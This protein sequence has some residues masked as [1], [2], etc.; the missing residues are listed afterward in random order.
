VVP[1]IQPSPADFKAAL[2][3]FAESK[4][5]ALEKLT[6]S[7]ALKEKA[8][9]GCPPKL[10]SD[11]RM[12]L[13]GES[14]QAITARSP[15]FARHL[16]WMPVQT[17]RA[18]TETIQRGDA[19]EC[20][21]DGARICGVLYGYDFKGRPVILQKGGK[22]RTGT[23]DK[24]RVLTA[25]L[26]T[27]TQPVVGMNATTVSTPSPVLD[28]GLKAALD[29]AVCGAHTAREYVNALSA[30]GY[31]VF[32]VGGALRDA[33][34]TQRENP[35]AT[36]ADLAKALSDVDLVTTA[37]VS[38]LREIAAQIAPELPGAGIHSPNVVDQFGVVLVGGPKAHLPNK[39][40]L[41]LASLRSAG[42]GERQT[43]N[44]DT[45]D[46]VVPLVFDHNIEE[47][48]WARDFACNSIYAHYDP[49]SGG[50]SLVD[51]TGHG[52]EDAE[53]LFLRVNRAHLAK[54]EDLSL[55]FFKFRM[56]GYASDAENIALAKG[57]AER[58][59]KSLG[60]KRLANAVLRIMPKDVKTPEALDAYLS[61]L[62]ATMAADG[63]ATLFDD[64]VTKVRDRVWAKLQL[65]L[66][67][68]A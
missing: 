6:L 28:A 63:C 46:T 43:Y 38:V 39:E 35:H 25:P 19:I 1:N 17:G 16:D 14:K 40:G 64:H 20:M 61:K 12:Q 49:K 48:A 67:T 13:I 65:R 54:S 29:L 15:L 53:N 60:P 62:R 33:L 66:G 50:F 58:Y 42:I 57:H 68:S 34:R 51:P 23:W 5:V 2:R 4:G 22:R 56:R 24:T 47:D 9:V 26:S 44:P 41:D 32:I 27:Q 55:R 36:P 52:L 18:V 8:L 37:P 30:R 21:I 10:L 7:D 59:L 45:Q 11:L 31:S 3:R